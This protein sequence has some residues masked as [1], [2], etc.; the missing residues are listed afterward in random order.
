MPAPTLMKLWAASC[1]RRSSVSFCDSISCAREASGSVWM[2]S[3]CRAR[4]L[5][6]E[7]VDAG[8][9]DPAHQLAGAKRFLAQARTKLRE[10]GAFKVEQIDGHGRGS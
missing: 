8:L 6:V 5:S 3:F 1:S 10:P 7:I 2:A 9:M 4:G